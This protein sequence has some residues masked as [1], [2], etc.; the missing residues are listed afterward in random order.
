VFRFTEVG[1]GLATIEEICMD[2]TEALD[3]PTVDQRRYLAEVLGGYLV[4]IGDRAPTS[5]EL[6][7]ILLGEEVM[8][9]IEQLP[10]VQAPS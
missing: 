4:H 9:D 3:L 8:L 7:A 10:M 1:P 6:E 5:A 2:G